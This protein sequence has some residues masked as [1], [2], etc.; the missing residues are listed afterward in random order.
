MFYEVYD[1]GGYLDEIAAILGLRIGIHQKSMSADH[2][3][4]RFAGFPTVSLRNYLDVLLEHGKTVA[5]VDQMK[6]SPTSDAITRKVSRIVTPGTLLDESDLKNTDN[7]FLLSVFP[8]P[9]TSPKQ[10]GLAWVDVSTGEFNLSHTTPKKFRDV[11]VRI[12][13]REIL[14]PDDL[15]SAHPAIDSCLADFSGLVTRKPAE[16]FRSEHSLGLLARV[17]T[18][19][20]PSKAIFSSRPKDALRGLKPLQI[21][22][23][24]ALLAYLAE[25]FPAAQPVIRAPLEIVAQ[26]SMVMDVSTV[27]ALEITHTQREKSKKGSLLA[28]IDKTKTASGHRLL[29]SRLIAP[30][31]M[32]EEINRRLDLV[33]VF[34]HDPHLTTELT[35][36]LGQCKDIERALQRI[37]FETGVPSDLL[38]VTHTLAVAKEVKQ[39]LAKKIA[40]MS[41]ECSQRRVL[42]ALVERIADFAETTGLLNGLLNEE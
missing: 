31:T 6:P 13:P 36:L 8:P 9:A 10:I 24:G 18:T 17:I 25:T 7:N 19:N 39:L 11:L 1:C 37:H 22:A 15:A 32:L 40:G 16:L 29:A 26:E 12:Q 34:Y 41:E 30:S 27:E 42:Q 21:Q 2:R 5:I 35:Q 33:E 38:T 4:N 14:A 20:D 28:A 23:A 3:Y